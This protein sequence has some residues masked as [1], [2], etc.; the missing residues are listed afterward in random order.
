MKKVSYRKTKD[1]YVIT[2]D[3]CECIEMAESKLLILQQELPYISRRFLEEKRRFDTLK[4]SIDDCK[5]FI[6]TAK[7]ELKRRVFEEENENKG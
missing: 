3:L 1:G 7:N 5:L 6:V 4:K 2:G